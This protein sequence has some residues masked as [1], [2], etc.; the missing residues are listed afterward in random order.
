MV[1]AATAATAWLQLLT[2]MGMVACSVASLTPPAPDYLSVT[3]D[4][5]VVGYLPTC[6]ADKVVR[7]WVQLARNHPIQQSSKLHTV[8]S[9]SLQHAH[10]YPHFCMSR[11]AR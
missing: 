9:W 5:K 8:T 2:D 11:F 6:V 10:I 4:G 3:L 1:P 7:R